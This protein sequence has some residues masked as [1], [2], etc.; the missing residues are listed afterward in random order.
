[1]CDLGD[2]AGHD[3]AVWPT[4]RPSPP[5][6][7]HVLAS[8]RLGP[9]SLAPDPEVAIGPNVPIGPGNRALDRGSE[10]SPPTDPS[11][12]G[13]PDGPGKS[14]QR[15]QG[16]SFPTSRGLG[17][18]VRTNRIASTRTPSAGSQF[19]GNRPGLPDPAIP[20]GAMASEYLIWAANA[21]TRRDRRSTQNEAAV[22]ASPRAGT[23]N[24]IRKL[25]QFRHLK[26]GPP[27]AGLS[28][29][30]AGGGRGRGRGL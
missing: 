21:N 23:V 27:A 16:G 14:A 29:R 8:D 17:T 13:Q 28:P 18:M 20:S 9:S 12:L 6:T 5:T 19:P 1:M 10:P 4:E 22:R 26:T 30:L 3:L 2:A 7:P 24:G 25:I 11:A 15:D